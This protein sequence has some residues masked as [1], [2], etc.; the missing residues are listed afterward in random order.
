MI[1]GYWRRASIDNCQ[2]PRNG[3]Q[4]TAR[5]IEPRTAADSNRAA[6]YFFH[7]QHR[8]PRVTMMSCSR[9]RCTSTLRILGT[10][11]LRA[12]TADRLDLACS[13]SEAR[14]SSPSEFPAT[15]RSLVGSR[16]R[17]RL[18]TFSRGPP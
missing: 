11:G 14:Y 15:S 4:A 12:G 7:A 18:M 5:S 9:T 1:S 13:C 8:V 16:L 6:F 3:Q 10:S 17:R 2:A